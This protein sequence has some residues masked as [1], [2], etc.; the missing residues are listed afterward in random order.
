MKR[1]LLLIFSFCFMALAGAQTLEPKKDAK[2]PKWGYVDSH[3]GKWVVKPVYDVAEP[4][5]K[6]PDGRYRA[7]VT[8]GT[9]QGFLGVDGKLLGAKLVFEKIEPV[10]EGDNMIVTVKGKKGIIDLDGVYIIKPEYTDLRQAGDL[11][12]ISY[13]KDKT[14]FIDARGRLVCAPEY[15]DIDLSLPEVFIV[16][17]NGKKGIITHSGKIMLEP[18]VYTDVTPLGKYWK[19]IKDNKAGIWDM[20]TSQLLIEPKYGD[21]KAPVNLKSGTYLPVCNKKGMWGVLDTRGKEILKCRHTTLSVVPSLN[22]IMVCR[23]NG[24]N[25]IWFPQYNI[26]LE[27]AEWKE[28]KK[29][30]FFFIEGELAQPT[31]NVPGHLMSALSYGERDAYMSD[32]D[33]RAKLYR[34]IASKFTVLTDSEGNL[35]SDSKNVRVIPLDSYWVVN[36]GDNPWSIYS[37]KGEPVRKTGLRGE[38]ESQKGKNWLSD[39]SRIL[40]PDTR[41]YEIKSFGEKLMFIF[42]PDSKTWIPVLNNTPQWNME[43]FT[44]VIKYDDNTATV[45]QNGLWG[46]IDEKGMRRECKFKSPLR[47]SSIEGFMEIGE[48][49]KLGLATTDGKEVLPPVYRNFKMADS[50]KIYVFDEEYAGIYDLKTQLWLIP[51]DRKYTKIEKNDGIYTVWKYNKKGIVSENGKEI[52]PP[53]Y[54]EIKNTWI[55]GDAYQCISDYNT[56]YF[57]IYG[58]TVSPDPKAWLS[59]LSREGNRMRDGAK[60]EMQWVDIN[61]RFMKGHT[62]K[63][64][65]LVCNANGSPHISTKK[66]TLKWEYVVTVDSDEWVDDDNW[67]HIPYTLFNVPRNSSK[68]FYIKYTLYD[69]TDGKNKLLDTQRIDFGV[70]NGY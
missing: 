65:K 42:L 39:G 5:K 12:Y 31:K 66:K 37:A 46:L 7:L 8:K 22:A 38:A 6:S 48:P 10:M 54:I 21:V 18:K 43:G 56:D 2:K 34:Y 47:Q 11:G 25:R 52:V 24:G 16:T 32:Y 26:I 61:A 23:N 3:T 15:S 30:P 1:L 27:L 49:G 62:L 60:G 13:I 44:E 68:D 40:M 28:S 35:V 45:Q 58:E 69:I 50:G 63:L 14:G 4:F 57:N 36:D 19:V 29:G 9:L 59:D 67:Y 64:V 53:V 70:R 41:E 55:N 17:K 20:N 51:M 33:R